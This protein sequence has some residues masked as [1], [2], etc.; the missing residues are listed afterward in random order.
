MPPGKMFDRSRFGSFH[1][2]GSVRDG[3]EK[4]HWHLP[5]GSLRSGMAVH[6][7]DPRYP[8]LTSATILANLRRIDLA[9][10]SR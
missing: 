9:I 5:V 1:Q 6:G 7:P 8:I 4:F 10:F 2:K 3:A